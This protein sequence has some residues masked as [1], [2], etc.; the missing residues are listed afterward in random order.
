M[1]D[2]ERRLPVR[3]EWRY[4]WVS[5]RTDDSDGDGVVHEMADVID[6]D[7]DFVALPKSVRPGRH[8]H[9]TGTGR[10]RTDVPQSRSVETRHL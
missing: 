2:R 6:I 3:R 7:G 10:I 1:R 5:T 4:G 9:H 8:E